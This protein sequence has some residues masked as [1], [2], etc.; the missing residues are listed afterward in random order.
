VPLTLIQ[1]ILPLII[2]EKGIIVRN[3]ELDDC[4]RCKTGVCGH[5]SCLLGKGYYGL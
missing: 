5:G 1:N 3:H 2:V 4:S